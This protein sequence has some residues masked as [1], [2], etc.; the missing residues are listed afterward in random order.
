[1]RDQKETNGPEP[2]SL[3][4]LYTCP[5]NPAVLNLQR[6]EKKD[7]RLSV[8]LHIWNQWSAWQLPP[9]KH[10]D[11][12]VKPGVQ[13]C[14]AYQQVAGVIME[15]AELRIEPSELPL[16]PGAAHKNL[17]LPSM[18]LSLWMAEAVA[19]Y[20]KPTDRILYLDLEPGDP[21][22]SHLLLGQILA[23]MECEEY[24]AVR[25]APVHHLRVVEHHREV[26]A[27]KYWHKLFNLSGSYYNPPMAL[28]AVTAWAQVAAASLLAG[29][30]A[31]DDNDTESER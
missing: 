31:D 22:N 27:K 4:L 24:N 25:P 7:G 12:S 19:Y 23:Q 20:F 18:D 9:G 11:F 17:H 21:Y 10:L 28:N 2:H 16:D 30:L 29:D 5:S 26:D 13:G 6:P 14:P 1:M 15:S 8:H 3:Q